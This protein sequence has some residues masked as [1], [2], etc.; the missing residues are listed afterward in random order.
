MNNWHCRRIKW[1]RWSRVAPRYWMVWPLHEMWSTD[2]ALTFCLGP[3]K[4]NSV[5]PRCNDNLLQISHS[6]KVSRSRVSRDSMSFLFLPVTKMAESSA[7]RS[8]LCLTNL[9]NRN[10]NFVNYFDIYWSMFFLYQNIY[11]ICKM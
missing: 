9:T 10:Y 11:F 7:Y 4:I 1:K 8:N 2:W 3:S 6:Q 5:L